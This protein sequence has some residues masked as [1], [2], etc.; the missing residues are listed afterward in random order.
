MQET[1]TTARAAELIRS[2]PGK[3][4]AADVITKKIR[5]EHPFTPEDQLPRRRFVARTGV[6]VGVTGAGRKFTPG[7][8]LI[9]IAEMP[10]TVRDEQGR[11]RAEGPMSENGSH[12]RFLT[13]AGIRGLRI[14]GKSYRVVPA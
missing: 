1:I 9:Q 11:I 7:A 5:K 12:F 3:V 8:D 6:S 14:A 2:N 4:F 10:P 13:V